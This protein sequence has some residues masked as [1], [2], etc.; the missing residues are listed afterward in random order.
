MA[1]SVD[2][3]Q[4]IGVKFF[5][6]E[7]PD[8]EKVI[9]VFHRWIQ[10][11][12]VDGMLIDVADYSHVEQ[13]PGVLLVGHEGN[14][15]VDWTRNRPGV[16]YYRKQPLE[17]D[18]GERL[19]TVCETALQAAELLED[20]SDL[21]AGAKLRGDEVQ[22]F[23]NDRLLAPNDAGTQSAFQPALDGLLDRLFNG[24]S[25]QLCRDEDPKE[26]F[27]MDVKAETGAAAAALRARLN[28]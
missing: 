4:R 18:L 24:S 27:N 6:S 28:D 16:V 12:S 26:R 3:L 11:G 5:L 9:G 1:H 13:G 15:A 25:R 7:A 10:N 17:G 21:G 2:N 20:E 8:P 23:A 14:Y 22:I 19:R